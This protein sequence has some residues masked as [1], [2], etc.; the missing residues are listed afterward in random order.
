M[1]KILV[2]ITTT[3]IL[4]S[5]FVPSFAS[6]ALKQNTVYSPL[7]SIGEK[8][9]EVDTYDA[10]LKYR[11]DP[12][13]KY[14]FLIK[15]PP[16]Q[17]R[18]ADYCPSCGLKYYILTNYVTEEISGYS[19]GCPYNPL[20]PDI[21]WTYANWHDEVCNACGY[22]TTVR[23]ADTYKSQCLNPEAYDQQIFEVRKEWTLENGHEIHEVYDY[24]IDP[25]GFWNKSN[26]IF[27]RN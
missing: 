2:F 11:Q 16:V 3:I 20:S 1:K 12:R 9:V 19:V 23:T 18:R 6:D 21:F 25:E 27:S 8:T 10:F 22:R 14:T 17:Q 13:Y 15:T 4:L 7:L 5:S 24:W 26:I